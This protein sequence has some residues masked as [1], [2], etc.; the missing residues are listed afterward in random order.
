MRTPNIIARILCTAALFCAI[1][2]VA[3]QQEQKPLTVSGDLLSGYSGMNNGGLLQSGPYIGLD[4]VAQGFWKDPRILSFSVS[5]S[6]G[7]GFTGSGTTSGPMG[8]GVTAAATFL[9][10]SRFP[11]TVSYGYQ[12]MPAPD[13][14]R[15]TS[16]FQGFSLT[17]K[18]FGVDWGVNLKRLPPIQ[19][20]YRRTSDDSE[21]P[22]FGSN[23]NRNRD[24]TASTQYR[25]IGWSLSGNY[26]NTHSE[27]GGASFTS[28]DNGS[29]ILAQSDTQSAS[30]T[31]I[32]DL[33]FHSRMLV[34]GGWTS[35]DLDVLGSTTSSNY[36]NA[37]ASLTS[38]PFSRLNLDFHT[39]YVSNLSDLLR[40]QLLQT[41]PSGTTPVTPLLAQTLGHETLTYGAG[42][43]LRIIDG[44]SINTT[45]SASEP[46][47]TTGQD[48]TAG[49][50]RG[51]GAG[52]SFNHRVLNGE[53][54]SAYNHSISSND[55]GNAQ[56]SLTKSETTS[57]NVIAGY[58][59]S[60]PLAI[61]ASASATYEISELHY[62]NNDKFRSLT[63][64]FR[65]IRKVG[66]GWTLNTNYNYRTGSHE[67]PSYEQNGS[68]VISASL[69]SK[70]LQ[71]TGSY[72]RSFGLAYLFGSQLVFVPGATQFG[73]I[74]G[75]PALSRS[76]SSSYNVSASF[77]ATRHLSVNGAYY[78]GSSSSSSTFH[79]SMDGFDGNA[80]YRF[81]QIWLVGGYRRDMRGVSAASVPS[82]ASQSFYVMMRRHFTLF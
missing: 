29:A 61:S 79:E 51:I 47:A 78:R 8:E 12:F 41:D 58:S 25:L 38:Q 30:G 72:N 48:L 50:G 34:Q 10:G 52:I 18:E 65:A 67:Y 74:P 1:S 69:D 9:G 46:L 6:Y 14:N 22:G 77:K 24:F 54:F 56:A 21:T 43:G 33:P 44:L 11:A 75:L 60:L 80:T 55:I 2:A 62:T 49:A 66:A 40:S 23:D 37:N 53:F 5:P 76:N 81:R 63:L 15:T 35:T 20:S 27:A 45:Y 17:R 70:R 73:D 68:H 16:D 7:Q 3:Q 31:G 64:S 28:S 57:D 32:H 59:H 26:S 42:A 4:G 39:G 36:K 13:I 19:L 82:Y 71:F